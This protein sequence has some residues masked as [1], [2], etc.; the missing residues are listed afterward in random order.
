MSAVDTSPARYAREVAHAR[1]LF[2][3]PL[4]RF[5]PRGALA[6]YD[7]VEDRAVLSF[8]AG[9]TH[10]YAGDHDER[11]SAYPLGKVLQRARE[12]FGDGVNVDLA[13]ALFGGEGARNPGPEVT[14]VALDAPDL[15]VE[16]SDFGTGTYSV[17]LHFENV[18]RLAAGSRDSK[19]SRF[20]AKAEKLGALVERDQEEIYRRG[21]APAAAE[22]AVG[23]EA[24]AI[25]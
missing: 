19:G 2:A 24:P 21:N 14:D 20:F 1:A 12:V 5:A 3:G 15:A 11:G 8:P 23:D 10:V 4:E 22:P 9:N 6:T 17:C 18:S 7:E 25:G 16:V 13:T